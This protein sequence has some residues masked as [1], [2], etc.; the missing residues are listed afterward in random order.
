L[1][2][3]LRPGCEAMKRS[4]LKMLL[5]GMVVLAATAMA[6][7]AKSFPTEFMAGLKESK[8]I[9]VATVRRDG[10]RSTV[11]PVWFG[12]IEGAIWFATP[13]KSYKAKRVRHGS[14][15]FVSVQGKDGPFVQTKAEIVKDGV[16]AERLGEIYARKYWI[17][18]LGMFRP[19]RK[20][21]DTGKDVLI[22]LTPLP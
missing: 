5:V 17:A 16:I 10:K 4:L 6:D 12:I 20:K 19:S 21:M 13:P 14:P 18:W 15:M 8:Q 22:R 9:Y 1:G 11:V 7:E 2:R 3:G